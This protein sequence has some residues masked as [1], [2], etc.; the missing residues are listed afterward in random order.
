[1]TS[2]RCGGGD[3]E[4]G[5]TLEGV[6]RLGVF[7]GAKKQTAQDDITAQ[8]PR[9][10]HAAANK[11]PRRRGDIQEIDD[12]EQNCPDGLRGV[13]AEGPPEDLEFKLFGA[14]TKHH[15]GDARERKRDV[16]TDGMGVDALRCERAETVIEIGGDRDGVVVF[17]EEG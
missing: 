3:D 4:D 9:P 14:G 6:T 1:M 17:V 11:C 12:A 5:K 15:V 2:E 10:G 8:H 13:V 16:V 7:H